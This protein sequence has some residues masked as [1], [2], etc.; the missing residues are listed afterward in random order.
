MQQVSQIIFKVNTANGSGSAFYLKQYN[1]FV[2][3]Y[4]V[5]KGSKMVSIE[6]KN[7]DRFVGKVILA[8]VN[9]DLALIKTDA[10]FSALPD[11]QFSEVADI[12]LRDEVYVLGYPY[13]MPYTETQGIISSPRQL[14]NG[15]YYIQTDA[16]VNPGNSGGPL[17]NKKGE[18]IGVT[19]SKF[20]DADNMGF[21]VPVDT[22]KEVIAIYAAQQTTQYS[23]VCPGCRSVIEEAGEYCNNCGDTIDATLFD[24]MEISALANIIEQ[25]FVKHGIDPVLARTGYE[26]WNFHSGSS[27]IRIFVYNR[28]YVYATSP[29][30]KMMS[31]QMPDLLKHLLSPS[32]HPYQLGVSDGD[33]YISYRVHISDLFNEKY[34]AEELEK[35]VKLSEKADA[36]DNYLLETFGAPLAAEAKVA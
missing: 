6:N 15:K 31:K 16:P 4:H 8:D 2:T 35:L 7:L 26:Y 24:D 9:E 3:N 34:G 23:V 27:L 22:L 1:V 17:V 12:L 32:Q 25:G 29:I 28:S 13:G 18:I 30:N 19:T 14:M 10:D 11:V 33:I 21:A 5:V 36:T 20:S